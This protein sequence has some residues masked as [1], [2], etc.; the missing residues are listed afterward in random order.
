M[1]F[2]DA[3]DDITSMFENPKVQTVLGA[4]SQSV[5]PPQDARV[6]EN[7]SVPFG[8]TFE[9]GA[10]LR[11]EAQQQDA[12]ADA[13]RAA[14]A[15]AQSEAQRIALE[16]RRV[17][18]G[19]RAGAHERSKNV[20]SDAEELDKRISADENRTVMEATFA[21]ERAAKEHEYNLREIAD[22][23]ENQLI[24]QEQM[25]GLEQGSPMYMAQVNNL[26]SSTE[27][28]IARAISE[29][30]LETNQMID[31]ARRSVR[32]LQSR[33]ERPEPTPESM[34]IIYGI[35]DKQ[36]AALGER[37]GGVPGFDLAA[38]EKR[39]GLSIAMQGYKMNAVGVDI[40]QHF[41][42]VSEMRRMRELDDIYRRAMATG[43][44]TEYNKAQMAV[45]TD[46]LDNASLDGSAGNYNWS[47]SPNAPATMGGGDVDAGMGRLESI[48]PTGPLRV[49]PQPAPRHAPGTGKAEVAFQQSGEAGQWPSDAEA[50]KRIRERRE[51]A[52]ELM[53]Q[54]YPT[55][56]AERI[57]DS[58][59]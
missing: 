27:L 47:G 56:A 54:S 1:P 42:P 53:R 37:F 19:E 31:G 44:W 48:Q 26:N 39:T 11:G 40:F 7:L 25:L 17:S 6:A 15:Q 10:M 55:S 43:D 30:S 35:I 18:E 32:S 24:N 49:P 4:L 45:D 9:Q 28:N 52:A 14:E 16:G 57:V 46:L 20:L 5:R 8:A 51:R 34:D 38:E 23:Y 12:Y 13:R 36:V 21:D 2:K 59:R 29:F 22:T 3:L 41:L 58:L 33:Q 50:A